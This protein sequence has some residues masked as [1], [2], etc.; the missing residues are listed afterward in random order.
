MQTLRLGTRP[1]DN[2][3][4]GGEGPVVSKNN[5]G[6]RG[7]PWGALD[8]PLGVNRYLDYTRGK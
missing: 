8:P 5:L 7:G 6:L 1:L 2:G 3:G 4:G